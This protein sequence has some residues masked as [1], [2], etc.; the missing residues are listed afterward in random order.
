MNMKRERLELKELAVL[1][2]P[3][4]RYTVESERSILLNHSSCYNHSWNACF[5]LA[6][7]LKQSK[8]LESVLSLS[9]T[10][11]RMLKI[12]IMIQILICG[13]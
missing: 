10:I 8:D 3:I 6:H 7:K 5:P 1:C 4:F 12:M 9:L 2:C 13:L 11:S